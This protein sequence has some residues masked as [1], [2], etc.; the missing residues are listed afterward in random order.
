METRFLQDN[1][2]PVKV[3]PADDNAEEDHAYDAHSIVLINITLIA[4][5]FV[6]Y[7]IKKHRIYALPESAAA[8]LTG[9]V[10]GGLAKL[11][12]PHD[13]LTL[14]EFNPEVFFFILLPPIIFEAGYTLRR[15]H[16]FA[17]I[18][19]IVS[20]AFVGT[21]VSTFVI[22]GFTYLIGKTG[23]TSGVDATNPMESLLFGSLISAVDPVATLSIMGSPELQCDPL[24]YSLVFGESVLNDAVAIV[25][26]KTF[27][28]YYSPDDPDLEGGDV[29]KAM[30]AFCYISIG[31]IVVG[32]LLGLMASFIYK[33]TQLY[34]YP[35]FETSLLFLFCYLCYSLA[36][37]LELSGIMALFF[38]GILL[39]HYNSYN[40]SETAYVT[41]EQIFATLATV[42]E[43]LVFL[44]MGLSVFTGSFVGWNPIV[45]ILMMAFCVF[46]RA[47]HIFPLT[48]L[49]NLCRRE[50]QKIPM[51][52]QYVLW[53]VGLRGAIAFALAENMPGP[54]KQSYIANTLFICI[55]TTVVCGGFTERMLTK[56]GMKQPGNSQV[57]LEDSGNVYE[58]LMTPET[59]RMTRSGS[60]GR[61]QEGIHGFWK[62]LDTMYL[63]PNF[64]GSGEPRRHS[65]T[66]EHHRND[67]N[68]R[69]PDD[70]EDED[71]DITE[72][73]SWLESGITS[74]RRSSS[75]GGPGDEDS[76]DGSLYDPP[77]RSETQ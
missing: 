51:K 31:S 48:Y 55:F 37:S 76:Q 74:G 24:L 69:M 72:M 21:I 17:N 25:L 62:R 61:I 28:K 14:L 9:V 4:C 39:S 49:V 73:T 23:L 20:Y 7:L 18:T 59:P 71:E 22:G 27:R 13:S 19:P 26:F 47:C 50:G 15:K 63:K 36:E 42:C 33:H 3:E 40:L 5:I 65:T 70:D 12:S 54:N 32:V 75:V 38:N 8:L 67:S 41:A 6:A 35:K 46:A 2:E 64:G 66:S 52:M 16:F 29:P 77:V 44:Y 68:I 60:V 1:L 43:T 11:T 57:D 53:F 58:T 10:I 45:S 34:A 56:F 30:F